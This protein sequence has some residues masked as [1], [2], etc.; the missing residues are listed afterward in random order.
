MPIS[1][2]FLRKRFESANALAAKAGRC[3][4]TSFLRV[5]KAPTAG[6]GKITFDIAKRN[7][8]APGERKLDINDTFV[9]TALGLYINTEVTAKAGSG[10]LD[11]YPVA[12]KLTSPVDFYAIYNG[13]VSIKTGQTVNFEAIPARSF[14]HI[15]QTQPVSVLDSE[16]AKVDAGL[17]PQFD[18]TDHAL[19][20]PEEVTFSGAKTPEI[21]LEFPT[22]AGAD[23]S[24]LV[25]TNNIKMSLIVYGYLIKST[26]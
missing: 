23:F 1:I 26:N 21:N 20:L 4:E 13:A 14:L 3:A 2:E 25:N 19:Y 11:T 5:D 17:V 6:S 22:Y 15:P 7:G 18:V 24:A 8:E 12:A 16:D 10:I 9:V